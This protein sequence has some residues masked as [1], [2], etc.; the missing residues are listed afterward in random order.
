MSR[1]Q[2]VINMKSFNIQY[3]DVCLIQQTIGLN[4]N[5]ITVALGAIS[6][7]I[8]SV[9]PSVIPSI[10]QLHMLS[11]QQLHDAW[12]DLQIILHKC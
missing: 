7:S 8:V 9:R 5:T 3:R 12:T 4:E 10:Y 1:S 2:G 11:D 6:C